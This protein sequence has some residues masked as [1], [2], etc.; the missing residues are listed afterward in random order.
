M[1]SSASHVDALESRVKTL[2]ARNRDTVALHEAKS[3]AHDRLAEELSTQHQKLVS[4]R[5]Q[6]S[7]LEDKKQE[8]EASAK[9]VTFREN[10]LRQEIELLRKN[11]EWLEGELKA[12]SAD[13]TR[14]RKDKNAQLVELQRTNVDATLT[15]ESLRTKEASQ[16][17]RI[18]ELEQRVEQSLLQVQKLQEEASTKEEQFRAELDNRGH[19]AKLH[20]KAANT[21]KQ[22]L[23]DIMEELNSIKDRAAIELGQLQAEVES[24]RIKAAEYESRVAELESVVENQEAQL[25]ELRIPAHMP[26]TPRRPMNSS[27][28]TPGRPG[29]PMVFSPGGSRLKGG[30]S[31]TQLYAENTKLKADIRILQDREEK[32]TATMNEMLEELENRQPEIEELRQENERL[33]AETGDISALLEEAITEKDTARKET[34]KVQGDYQGLVRQRELDRQIIRDATFQTKLLLYQQ[35]SQEE[36]LE[37]LSQEE[38]QFLKDTVQ[39]SIPDHLLDEDDT[40][41]SRLI[42]QH[43]VLFHNVSDLVDKNHELLETIRKVADQYEGSEA[44]AKAAEQEKIQEELSSLRERLAQHEDEVKSLN[45][46]SQTFMKERDMYRRIATSRGHNAA[47][48]DS[49]SLIE[50]TPPPGI[51]APSVQQTPQSREAAEHGNV[52]KDL[53]KHLDIMREEYTMDRTT[54]KEQADS[55]T[56]EIRQLQTDNL[57]LQTKQETS[58]QR[59]EQQQH[60]ISTLES[61]KQSLQRRLDAAQDQL[62]GNDSKFQH[63]MEE[64]VEYKSQIE[65]LERA[66][67]NLKASQ[68]LWDTTRSRLENEIKSLTEAKNL[69]SKSLDEKR[70]DYNEQSLMQ[71]ENRRLLETTV[72]SLQADLA[73]ARRKLE[74]DVEEHKRLSVRYELDQADKQRKVDDLL[75]AANE[76]RQELASMKT[77]RD[78]LQSRVSELQTDLRL[79]EERMPQPSHINGSAAEEGDD[80]GLE[81]QL[82]TEIS[83]VQ[84]DLLRAQERLETTNTEIE[85][86]K[87]IAQEAEERLREY[88]EAQEQDD[89]ERA[90]ID[91][92]KDTEIADLK[93]RVDEISTELATTNTELSKVRGIHENEKLELS[94]KKDDLEAQISRMQDDVNDYKAEMETQKQ[95]VVSQADIATRAQ[96]DYENELAKHGE[97]MK[98]LRA[99][100]EQHNKLSTE[101]MQYKTEAEAAR[102]SLAQNEE[103]WTSVEERLARELTEAQTRYDKVAGENKKLY[104]QFDDLNKQIET[105][106]NSRVSVAAGQAEAVN[107]DSSLSGLQALNKSL[108]DDKDILQLKVNG[109]ELELQRVRQDLAHKQDQLDQASEKLFAEQSRAQ[110]RPSGPTVQALQDSIGQLNLYRESNT[111]LRNDVQRL[112]AERNEKYKELEGLRNQ[113]QPLQA[114]VSQLEGELEISNGHLKAVEEDRDRWQKRHQDVLQRYDRIDPKELED[115]KQQ[116]E[117]LQKERDEAVQQASGVEERVREAQ[118]QTKTM[119]ERKKQVQENARSKLQSERK[120]KQEIAAERDSFKSNLAI[121][122]GK[123]ETIQ[124]ELQSTQ[125]ARDDALKKAAASADAAAVEEGQVNESNATEMKKEMEQLEARL[126]AAEGREKEQSNQSVHLGIQ[127]EALKARERSLEGQIVSSSHSDCPVMSLTS[128]KADLQQRI[129]VLAKEVE[130]AK[131]QKASAEARVLELQSQQ[132]LTQ[133]SGNAQSSGDI[134]KLR[135]ELA[136]RVKEVE[137]LRTRA[138]MTES[139]VANANEATRT[140]SSEEAANALAAKEAALE[141]RESALAKAEA[142]LEQR[143]AELELKETEFV[144]TGSSTGDANADDPLAIAEKKMANLKQKANDKIRALRQEYDTLKAEAAEQTAKIESLETEVKQLQDEIK[145]LKQKASEAAPNSTLPPPGASEREV[146]DYINGSNTAKQIIKRTVAR[147]AGQAREN[148]ASPAGA[149][150]E[151]LLAQKV[152]EATANAKAEHEKIL[153]Q[154]I[155]EVRAS[156]KNQF[157]KRYAAKESLSKNKFTRLKAQWDAVAQ[158]AT[159][160]PDLP[161]K[162]AFEVAKAAKPP[163]PPP[164]QPSKSELTAESPVQSS[165][166]QTIP[167]PSD[168]PETPVVAPSSNGLGQNQPVPPASDVSQSGG[169]NS[170]PSGQPSPGQA[171]FNHPV[172]N[173]FQQG[174]ASGNMFPMQPQMQNQNQNQFGFGGIPQ[175]GF[176]ATG[177]QGRPNSPFGLQQ[178]QHQQGG[179]DRGDFGTGPA[180]LRGIVAG[181]SNIPRGGGS[182]IPLPGGRNRGGGGRGGGG[183]GGHGGHGGH[184]G[185]PGSP[186]NPGAATF[187]P[188]GGRGQKRG[189]EDDAGGGQ[190]GGKRARGHGRGHAATD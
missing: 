7:E 59:Y 135:E 153:A 60:R 178:T 49:V 164:S 163:Q 23:Q 41:T 79:A 179:R 119:E 99:L 27:F 11:N 105:L 61:E 17:K 38:Q 95:L 74:E 186:M 20:E 16:T 63:L 182:N 53:Q 151:K 35:K 127:L 112:E 137:D 1:N 162:D 24:E 50:G 124:H 31:M 15:I 5:K 70:S 45:L 83:N 22:R 174:H 30:L 134:E 144:V 187:Q 145:E 141:D 100:R 184:G 170:G 109:M 19:L 65:S 118:E 111:T 36:G 122:E 40:A 78:Q 101:V 88:L 9:D 25:A 142:E 62:A 155:E 71:A 157:E 183:R 136:A 173:P 44:Q 114:R 67:T 58:Q 171:G 125:Q 54:L 117:T 43:L 150:Q 90:R 73:N 47:G 138:D 139:L 10:N 128:E 115:L 68:S 149:D 32:R 13:N 165:F 121:A 34:R 29:S 180:A 46:R 168:V 107:L 57:R 89:Q 14:F 181:Q 104:E 113:L 92:Q 98:N 108:R 4:L 161:V 156:E 6:V 12:R 188:G 106:Q 143:K 159:D 84:R 94:Q 147:L 80:L 56:K 82:R 146:Q 86:Y 87:D 28:D 129:G 172:F 33:T 166:V 39:N 77:A 97:T 177:N 189:A 126:V 130:E 140:A 154:K 102:A 72:S 116:I 96:Q 148:A 37:S 8:L 175:P 120:E 69:L 133:S 93:Q 21:S 132:P 103:H 185:Q 91:Q 176:T 3:A 66:N 85:T 190:R 160:T 123:L 48:H 52:L 131:A 169:S 167:E 18:E 2:E 158:A 26:S 51:N 152:E 110:N 76:V 64:N 75:K 42:S 55:L 81:E